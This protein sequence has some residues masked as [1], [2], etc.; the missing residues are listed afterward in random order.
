MSTGTILYDTE[1][2]K[3]ER[4]LAPNYSC[5]GICGRPWKFVEP[6][7]INVSEHRG[8]FAQCEDCWNTAT[9]HDIL[10][11]N[12]ILYHEYISEGLTEDEI[13]FSKEHLMQCVAKELKER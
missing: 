13:G 8:I 7:H 1:K 3:S 9:D 2:A 5:C 10:L 12:E 6:H 11:C 4:L